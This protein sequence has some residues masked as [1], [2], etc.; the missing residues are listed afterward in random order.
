[1]NRFL[2]SHKQ[3]LKDFIDDICSISAERSNFA[4]TSVLFNSDNNTRQAPFY[5]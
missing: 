4:V 5:V 2:A 3:G 1:M